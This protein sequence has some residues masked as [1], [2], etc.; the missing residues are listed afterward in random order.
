MDS[1][2]ILSA[3]PSLSSHTVARERQIQFKAKLR[4]ILK[5]F[6]YYLLVSQYRLKCYIVQSPTWIKINA[7]TCG[8]YN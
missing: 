5:A 1:I 6:H 3:V 7:Q 8:I 4:K 2:V